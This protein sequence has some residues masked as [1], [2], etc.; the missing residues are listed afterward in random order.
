MKKGKYIRTRIMAAGLVMTI[1]GACGA[2]EETSINEQNVTVTEAPVVTAAPTVSEEDSFLAA[3]RTEL[4]VQKSYLNYI[5]CE[6][7]VAEFEAQ[8]LLCEQLLQD[9]AS[10]GDMEIAVQTMEELQRRI[11]IQADIAMVLYHCN[12]QDAEARDNYLFSAEVL[13]E[14]KREKDLFLAELY[15]S[16]RYGRYFQYYTD[17]WQKYYET[18][19]GETAELEYRNAELLAEFNDLSE[20]EFEG[21]IGALYSEFVNN[22]NEIATKSGFANYYEY[23]TYMLYMREYGRE[24]REQLR[25]YAK[26][27][28]VPLYYASYEQYEAAYKEASEED[29]NF[30]SA[31]LKDSYD[32]LETDYVKAYLQILPE[33]CGAGMLHMFEEEAY[34]MPDNEDAWKGA[35]TTWVGATICYYGPDCQQAFTMIHELGHYYAAANA[36]A[37]SYDL[38]ETQSQGNEM[39]FLTYLGTVLEPKTYE[40]LRNYRLYHFIRLILMEIIM[41]E[42]E[43]T[44]Y[45]LP[46]QLDYT[47]EDFDKIMYDIL[48]SYGLAEDEYTRDYVEFL[49]RNAGMSHPVYHLNYATSAIASLNLYC[50][51]QEDFEA[52]LEA[53][54]IIQ[55]EVDTDRNFLGTLEKAGMDSVFEEE[56]YIRLQSLFE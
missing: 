5:L 3:G 17:V 37:Q 29:K 36:T 7:D 39:L 33:S 16:G 35:Y 2:K 1:F 19:S 47:A 23:A 24:E 25:Q 48:E 41:D 10:Y 52:A 6:E 28:I 53:Y 50:L 20:D 55:E 40:S 56:A 9:G 4:Q 27:Y 32:S 49:W 38:M 11:Q 54:R 18:Y 30:I 21:K 43:E 45:G 26:N 42:F 12:M 51:S 34:I 14:I 22:N 15:N 8:L 13:S 46:E 31:L 44:I